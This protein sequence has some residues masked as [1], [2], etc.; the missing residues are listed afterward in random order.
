MVVKTRIRS[1]NEFVFAFGGLLMSLISYYL[2]CIYTQANSKELKAEYTLDNAIMSD[3]TWL[4]VNMNNEN[5]FYTTNG[6]RPD[7]S[8]N[9]VKNGVLLNRYSNTT[10]CLNI[11]TALKW[12]QPHHIPNGVVVTMG[13]CTKKESKIYDPR[14]FIFKPHSLPVVS[15]VVKHE[16][17]FSDE[18][19]IYVPGNVYH[20]RNYFNYSEKWWEVP[21]NFSQRGPDWER[22]IFFEFISPEGKRLF[23]K[24]ATAGINGNST[25]GFA[26]KSLRIKFKKQKQKVRSGF[27]FFESNIE[28]SGLI[29]RNSGND[30]ERTL[31]A[32]VLMHDLCKSLN[33]LTHDSKHVIVYI[34]GNYWGIHSMVE[35]TDESLIS[36]K[37]NIKK[38]K[39][40]VFDGIKDHKPEEKRVFDEVRSMMNSYSTGKLS[41]SV[42][43]LEL[44][45][46]MNVRSLVSYTAAEIFF[47]NTDWPNNN[48]KM[49][50]VKDGNELERWSFILHD[51]DFAMAYSGIPKSYERD[52][53]KKINSGHSFIS[54][55]F[56]S[57]LRSKIFKAQLKSELLKLMNEELS[58][59]RIVK[60][61]DYYIEALLPEMDFH[62][63]RWRKPGSVKQWK[64]YCD[65]MIVFARHRKNTL[66]KQMNKWLK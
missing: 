9:C 14:L 53:F 28:H 2:F 3:G 49:F 43:W 11:P 8:A 37:F 42:K 59:D 56:S 55:F 12:Y 64:T 24:Y 1:Y 7:E 22:K 45:N 46:K 21:G 5:L 66:L 33:F 47:S 32:D 10:N 62:V 26:L 31:F 51:L 57:L 30:W 41:D 65:E 15:I 25:R 54:V 20:L 38:K 18:K 44:S 34:N 63:N 6:D 35:R 58:E 48:L 27:H 61:I 17:F 52:M 50:K 36:R 29:L 60:R 19:G 16:D 4:N 40:V 39:V 23:S 13:E